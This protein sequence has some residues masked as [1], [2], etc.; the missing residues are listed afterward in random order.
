MLQQILRDMYVDP[1]ILAELDEQ[2]KQT[3]FCKMR[4][5]QVRRW[6][7]WNEKLGEE[8][9]KPKARTKKKSVSFMKGSDGEPWVW[10]MGEHEYDKSIEDILNEEARE[11]ARKI[12]EKEAE[13]LRKQM[14]VQ[15]SEY[16][17]L[18]PKIEDLA[19]SQLDFQ[20]DVD[21]YCSVDELREKINTKSLQKPPIPKKPAY[22]LNSYQTKINKFN[23]VDARDVLNET[24]LNAQVAQRVALF[25][26]KMDERATEIFKCIRKKQEQ[27]AKEAEEEGRKKDQVWR[28]QERKA[29]A[30]ELQ[31]REIARRARAE[32][33]LTS[34]ME[35]DTSYSTVNIGVPPSRQPVVDWYKNTER[36]KLAGLENA[37]H[38]EPWFH[39]LI[40]RS[41]AEKLLLD[42]PYGTFLVRL[43]EK[44]WGYAISYRAEE[45]CKHYLVNASQKYHFCGNNQLEYETLGDLI[46]YHHIQPLSSGEK[47]IYP[48]PRLSSVAI[49]E[50]L[51]T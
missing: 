47:L 3:L 45:K 15:L 20:D 22:Q 13:Q 36:A 42:Q 18:S 50:L 14:E 39:G 10:V 40:T 44:I 9:I 41:Q 23:F 48:C 32:H 34:D 16:I 19:P 28:E 37:N 11:Q 1:E 8:S 33:R 35:I 4:E 26:K 25:E 27:A 17:E 12:A 29:K 43:S 38:A 49:D 2:Q 24:S 5:E 6:K 31:I 30:A 21:I 51:E 46:K 7:S